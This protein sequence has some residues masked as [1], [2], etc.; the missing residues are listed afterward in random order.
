MRGIGRSAQ[1][2]F[3]PTDVFVNGEK[4]AHWEVGEPAEFRTDIPPALLAGSGSLLVEFRTPM[5]IAPSE[6][7]G[8]SDT[9]VL[10][11]CVFELQITGR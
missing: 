2:P 10:G 8:N 5:A 6:L 11:L 9:R 7:G 4:V 1:L 3:Q